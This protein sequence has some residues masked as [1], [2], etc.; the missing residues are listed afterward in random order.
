MEPKT[1]LFIQRGIRLAFAIL[2]I[3]VFLCADI[4]MESGTINVL[5][6]TLCALLV[7]G[8]LLL[9][10]RFV[11]IPFYSYA[12]CGIY[13]AFSVFTFLTSYEFFEKYTLHLTLIRPEAYEAFEQLKVV[14]IVDSA[15]FALMMLSLLP[16]LSRLIKQYTGFSPVTQSN[17]QAEDKIRYVHDM[18]HKRLI[19]MA[20]LIGLCLISGICYILFVSS[21][22]FMWIVD[23]IVCSILAIY[24]MTTLSAI[25]QEVEYKYLLD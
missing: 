6:D 19:T 24:T 17:V 8:A 7:L 1:Y 2:A 12:F 25:A 23:F 13:A 5:P 11:K 9:L 10:R 3:G 16:V 20:V 15:F 22:N 14:E 21:A 4:Y 18:L